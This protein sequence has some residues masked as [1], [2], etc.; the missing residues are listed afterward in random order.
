MFK[1]L[2]LILVVRVVKYDYIV[3]V[4]EENDPFIHPKAWEALNRVQAKLSQRFL[5]VYSP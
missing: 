1:L 5:E 2:K 4:K 3:H